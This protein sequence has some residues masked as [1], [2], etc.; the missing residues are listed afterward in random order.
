MLVFRL[1]AN[2]GTR[3]AALLAWEKIQK[4]PISSELSIRQIKMD[5]MDKQMDKLFWTLFH[6]FLYLCKRKSNR[7]GTAHK[8]ADASCIEKN[9]R[10]WNSVADAG[11]DFYSPPASASFIIN[12]Q[13]KQSFI[14]HFARLFVLWLAPKI[15][16]LGNESKNIWIF[17]LHFA[18]LF[19]PLHTDTQI[20]YHLWRDL[21]RQLNNCV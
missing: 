1:W 6:S 12:Q 13:K 18:R 21:K 19:V 14:L 7:I 20:C 3:R 8:N 17:A 11:R 10:L 15:L 9:N 2:V 4:T 16:P 5:K